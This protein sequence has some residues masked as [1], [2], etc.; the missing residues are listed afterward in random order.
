[1]SITSPGVSN[2]PST[3]SKHSKRV[4]LSRRARTK[5]PALHK[6]RLTLASVLAAL[7]VAVMMGAASAD[8]TVA[9]APRWDAQLIAQPT[10]FKVGLYGETTNAYEVVLTD[11]GGAPPSGPVK[12]VVKLAPGVTVELVEEAFNGD[13]LPWSTDCEPAAEATEVVC[14][15]PGVV[16]HGA[17]FFFRVAVSNTAASVLTSE[18]EVEGGGAPTLHKAFS[19]FVS[20]EKAPFAITDFSSTITGPA[21]E[22]DAKAGDHPTL[23]NTL[24]TAPMETV[25]NAGEELPVYFP[26]RGAVR[27]DKDIV[28]DLPAGVVGNPTAAPRCP[29]QVFL[30]QQPATDNCPPGS[31]VGVFSI[32]GTSTVSQGDAGGGTVGDRNPIFNLAPEPG[33]PAEFGLYLKDL[34]HGVLAPATLAH[35]SQGYVIRVIAS[36]LVT[37]VDGP[38]YLQTSFFGNPQRAAGLPGVGKSLLTNPGDCSGHPLRTEVHID[39]WSNPASV[40]LRA[41]GTRDFGAAD[42]S[43]PQ[44]YSASSEAP[45]VSGCEALQ[46][47]PTIQVKPDAS[48]ADSPSGLGVKISVPQ[49]E[50]PEGLATPPLRDATV[51]LP[52]G[53]VVDPSSA[54]G[55]VGC[56]MAQLSPDSTDPGTC[57]DGSKL[58]T[59]MVKTPLIDHPLEGSVYLG[60]PECSPCSSADAASGKML[61]LDLEISEPTTGIVV[62]LPGTVSADPVSGQLTASFKE[63]PQLPFE[64]LELHIKSGTRAP[65]TTP[66]ACGEYTTTT[67]LMPWSAPQSGPDAT[68]QAPFNLASG[69]GGSAC[70]SSEAELANSPSF[71]VGTTAPLAG[72]YSPFVLKL[73]REDGSQRLTAVNVTLPPGLT[74]K[75]AGVAQ[76]SDAQLAAAAGHAGAAEQANPS[77]PAAS[78][79]GSV[80]VGAGSGSPFYVGGHAYLAG[81]Y[82]GAPFSLAIVTPAVAGPFDLGT[83]VV[84]AGLYIDPTTAQVTVKSDPIPTILAGI[85]LDIRSVAV[86]ISR[87]SFMLNPTDC[88]PT[89]VTGATLSTLGQTAPLSSRFQV[90]GCQGLPFKPVL[91]ASTEGKTSKADGASLSV[92]MVSPGIGQ[93]SV[94]KVDLTI[95]AILPSRL[96][97][98]QKACTE[99]V[100]NA[101]PASCPSASDIGTATVQ[102]PLLNAPLSGPVYFVSHGGAAFPD[103]EIILQGEGVTL[104]LD[105]HTQI[106]KGVTYSRFE[107]V[108]DAPFTSFEFNAPEG[109]YSIFGANGNLCQTEIHMP[110]TIVAQNGAVLD[111][112]TLVQPQGCPNKLTILS[113]KVKKRTLTLK[114]AVPGAGKLTATAKHLGTASKTASGRG[115]VTLSLTA[116]GRGKLT[117]KVKLTF[118]PSHGKKLTAALGAKLK[119]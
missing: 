57:P 70:V 86:T 71:D 81:P 10:N 59:A 77:C 103:T 116:K 88:N 99:A 73:G 13:S 36:E 18:V 111:Q 109:P 107:S 82:K 21:G 51:T 23:L 67:D 1:M 15:V 62:K 47:N 72:A 43:D 113:H 2:V 95:P 3:N 97:T 96:T 91:T 4:G 14:N 98:I 69:P 100:F 56:S 74:G 85:P 94:A 11:I 53:L 40:P 84:R 20:S 64:T 31:Q 89:S 87:P 117:T 37:A 119:S 66:P 104:V 49:N 65:L 68:P 26:P 50:E 30:A 78:E 101:N 29:I 118:S 112:S 48:T 24:L 19:T 93:A 7:A 6:G 38:Y 22:G 76:C 34:N 58:G 80:T 33:Y 115:V 44:W 5:A 90:G 105:G 12:V 42:F 92:K 75:L 79:L 106:K 110:T 83:V 16:R 17:D 35:T 54:D 52:P 9:P 45:A 63:N 55:L 32:G 41:D 28:V 61:K 60:T 114:I 46:F 102:T 8:A 108:P 25:F 39:T 27:N